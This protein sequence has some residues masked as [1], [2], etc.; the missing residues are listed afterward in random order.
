MLFLEISDLEPEVLKETEAATQLLESYP[1]DVPPQLLI[2]LEK[3]GRSLAQAYSAA[4]DLAQNTLQGKLEQ[5]DAQN[6]IKIPMI[7]SL[8]SLFFMTEKFLLNLF[9]WLLCF[10]RKL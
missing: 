5:R 3:D 7:F 2:A 10:Y 8:E 9:V 1:Q 4:R 6:V